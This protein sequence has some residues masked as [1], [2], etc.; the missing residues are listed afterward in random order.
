MK[1]HLVSGGCG[2]VGRNIVKRILNT[3]SDGIIV[4]DDLSVGTLP[5]TWDW[6][7][8]YVS[9]NIKDIEVIG[10]EARIFFFKQDFRNFLRNL[11]QDPL[12][13]K[14]NYGIEVQRFVDVFHFAAIVGGRAKIDGDPMMVAIDLAIDAEFFYW[15]VRHRPERVMYPSSSAAYPIGLQKEEDAVALKET[16][17]DFSG[18]LG[19]PDMTY[20]WSKLTGEYLGRI[21]AQYYGIHV[22]SVRPF[23]GYGEDQDLTYP[24]PSIAARAARKDDPF[25]VWGSGRQG[26]DFVHIDDC[27]DAIFL[28]LDNIKD[29]S[30][31]NIG[32]GRLNSFL[33]IIELFCSFA[34]YKPTVKPLLD[35]PVGVSK[36]HSDMTFVN[37][38]FGWKPKVS[39]E[40]GMKRVYEQAVKN[41]NKQK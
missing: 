30:A 22:A 31:I 6:M 9:K 11:I 34:G 10:K 37:N 12:Y 15:V 38:T 20:G 24:V 26:R 41:I 16:D 8:P 35:K 32:S 36:R 14:N 27:V 25:E 17:I 2:F 39:L 23:S 19:K 13:L 1:Y 7:Q 29:G 21:A 40:E 5:E 28:A 18:N 3:T 4:V 33:E